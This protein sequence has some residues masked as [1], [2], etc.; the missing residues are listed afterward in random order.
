MN[1]WKDGF[2]E[3]EARLIDLSTLQIVETKIFDWVFLISFIEN[4]FEWVRLPISELWD[5]NN[6]LC[7]RLGIPLLPICLSEKARS[8][9]ELQEEMREAVKQ[10]A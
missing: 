2:W 7:R 1:A 8:Q 5:C 9:V 4:R 6:E 3:R 10:A